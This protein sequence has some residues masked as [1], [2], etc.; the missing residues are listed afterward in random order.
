MSHAEARPSQTTER[1]RNS[2]DPPGG[3]RGRATDPPG[4]VLYVAGVMLLAAVALTVALSVRSLGEGDG[5]YLT[6]A[7]LLVL[8][9][10]SVLLKE[11]DTGSGVS[12]TFLVAVLI[13][14]IPLVG[15]GGAGLLG[16]LS[17]QFDFRTRLLVR[18]FNAAMTCAVISIGGLTYWRMGAPTDAVKVKSL[19]VAPAGISLSPLLTGM[20]WPLVVATVVA[21]LVNL[22]I[23][24]GMVQVTSRQ[25]RRFL[26]GT[27]G[28]T[29]PVYLANSL[30]CFVFVVLWVPAGVGPLSAVLI[31]VPLLV[32]RWI[33]VQ[34]G[35]EA[36]SHERVLTAIV[37]A[38]AGA[39]RVS[40][41]HAD[42]VD[43]SCG[44]LAARLG[45]S[46]RQTRSLHYAAILHDAGR[47]GLQRDR[48]T[49][50]TSEAE[51][52]DLDDLRRH[53]E[54]AERIVTDIEF[55]A[56]AA[57]AIRHHHE[58]MDGRGY[59]DGL[60]GEDIPLLARIIA[61]ADSYDALTTPLGS[62]PPMGDSD[63]VEHLRRRSGSQ[64]DPRVVEE[65]AGLVHEGSAAVRPEGNARRVAAELWW[66]H[67]DPSISELLA[68]RATVE[69]LDQP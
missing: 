17:Y 48:M 40:T 50:L 43:A 18:L 22:A 13:G 41:G 5:D 16:L 6:L 30:I 38:A 54:L 19:D 15:P 32:A 64:F 60:A 46:D 31:M 42:R 62:R 45:L 47:I 49:R 67:D 69:R 2:A 9:V 4:T 51:P 63:A 35:E 58:R 68:D 28:Q 55:L 1:A 12:I 11:V 23:L 21:A 8:A 7:V 14:A 61:V 56:E 29:L 37:T 44:A 53:P 39:E 52:A 65:L 59:P 26:T 36:R 33:F 10:S 27:F 34:Y 25:A 24:A 3:A 66:D 20:A 57:Q